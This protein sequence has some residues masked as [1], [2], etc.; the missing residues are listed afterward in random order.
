MF[1][2]S[3]TTISVGSENSSESG[4]PITRIN[5]SSSRSSQLDDSD[6]PD[7]A[8]G[9]ISADTTAK[10]SNN[11]KFIFVVFSTLI[12]AI[13]G[14]VFIKLKLVVIMEEG[15]KIQAHILSVWKESREFFS[16]RGAEIMLILTDKHLMFIKKTESKMRWWGANTQRQVVKFIQNKNVMVMIDGYTEEHLRIDLEN[17]KNQEVSFNNILDIDVKEKVWGSVLLL[18]ILEGEQS[19]KYQFSIVQDWVKYPLKDPMKHMKV[20]WSGFIKYVKDK[21][22]VTE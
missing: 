14:S 16:G 22:L 8:I 9:N 2:D 3:P 20:D 11:F 7:A 18:E 13:T 21:Q 1:P 19:K 4:P 10:I 5:S 12:K 6:W 17:R 15:E